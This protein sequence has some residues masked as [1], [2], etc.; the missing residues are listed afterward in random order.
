MTSLL[1]S[2]AETLIAVRQIFQYYLCEL[3]GPAAQSV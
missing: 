2:N 1:L 3:V